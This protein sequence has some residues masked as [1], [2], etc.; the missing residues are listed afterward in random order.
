MVQRMS[1]EH[2]QK[3]EF[4]AQHVRYLGLQMTTV[5]NT[6]AVEALLTHAGCNEY[7]LPMNE[8]ACNSTIGSP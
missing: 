6:T 1:A 2:D 3:F 7:S 5:V 4:L 8:S